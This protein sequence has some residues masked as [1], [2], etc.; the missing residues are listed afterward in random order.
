MKLARFVSHYNVA[1]TPFD[2]VDIDIGPIG[3]C[4][5]GVGLRRYEE[6]GTA[7][8][9][10]IVSKLL[11]QANGEKKCTINKTLLLVS[12]RGQDVNGYEIVH[13]LLKEVYFCNG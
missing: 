11:P 12:R 6:M 3:V 10:V 8:S 4:I 7:L 9:T 2:A 5:P 1:M 13:S